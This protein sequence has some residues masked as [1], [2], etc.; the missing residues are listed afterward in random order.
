MNVVKKFKANTKK[1]TW[2]HAVNGLL[3]TLELCEQNRQSL[4]RRE[5]L[6]NNTNHNQRGTRVKEKGEW[7]HSKEEHAL[8]RERSM[9]GN[10]FCP[11]G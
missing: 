5:A 8:Q 7:T 10:S 4:K 9:E 11:E 6:E 1:T 2:D 3:L